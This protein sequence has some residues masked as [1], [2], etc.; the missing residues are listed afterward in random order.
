MKRPNI[1]VMDSGW[2]EDAI[3]KYFHIGEEMFLHVDKKMPIGAQ[4]AYGTPGK[5]LETAYYSQIIKSTE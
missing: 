2:G 1:C 5:K 4:E 3:V